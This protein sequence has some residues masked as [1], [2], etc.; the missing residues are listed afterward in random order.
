MSS[1]GEVAL[2]CSTGEG[3]P[4]VPAGPPLG[5]AWGRNGVTHDD[6]NPLC[7]LWPGPRPVEGFEITNVTASAITV[8]WAL[9]RLQHSTVSRVRVSIR[10]MGDLAGRTVEL[11]SSVAKYTFL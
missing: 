3:D 2:S 4:E 1:V 5:G 6:R 7:L 9:H 10:Q 8:Q 11:N